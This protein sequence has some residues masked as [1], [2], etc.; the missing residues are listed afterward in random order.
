V[1]EPVT[2]T[3]QSID[4]QA[5][6][7]QADTTRLAEEPW[8]TRTSAFSSVQAPALA[9]IDRLTAVRSRPPTM[10]RTRPSP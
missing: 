9:V 1:A 7:S 2:E 5:E 8:A 3:F 4:S 6:P 10:T